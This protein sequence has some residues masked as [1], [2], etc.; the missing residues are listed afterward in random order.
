MVY[1]KKKPA[2]LKALPYESALVAIEGWVPGGRIIGL[3]KGQFSL[4]DLV[5]VL[6]EKTGPAHIVISTWSAGFRD[7]RAIEAM[8]ASGRVLSVMLITDRSYPTRQPGYALS[9]EEAFGKRN[10]RTTNI[11]AKFVL[12]RSEANTICI[13]SSMNLNKNDRC[14]N[15]D[16]DDDPEIYDFFYSFVNDV[17]EQSKQIGLI[18]NRKIIDPVFRRI[19]KNEAPSLETN[20]WETNP[21]E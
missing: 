16:V 2:L 12:L 4:I 5:N 20:P 14:E 11:H 13:R 1:A 10:I 7:I 17:F 6:L 18:E 21:W 9:V 8:K 19:M 15:F 3:T